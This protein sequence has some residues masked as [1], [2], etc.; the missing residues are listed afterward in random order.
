MLLK[1]CLFILAVL[2]FSIVF[3][4]EDGFSINTFHDESDR[5]FIDNTI[6]QFMQT[7]HIPGLSIAIAKQED[8]VLAKGYGF[9]DIENKVPV[10]ITHQ[11][12]IASVSKPITAV[13]I[14]Q[15]REQGE[16]T[17]DDKIFGTGGILASEYPV[18]DE[19]LKKITIQHLLEHTAGKEWA[20]DSNDPMFQ[21]PDL[22]QTALIRWVLKNRLITKTPGSEYAYSNFAYCLLGRV[23]EKLRGVA[24]QQYVRKNILQPIN[25]NSFAIGSK[26]LANTIFQVRYYP[27]SDEDPYWLPIARM[28][29]HGGWIS[30]AIDLVKFSMSIDGRRKDIL[31][32]KSIKLMTTASKHNSNYALGWNVNQYNNWW[33]M[34]SLPG[35]ASILVRTEH[36]YNWA[37]LLNSRSQDKDFFNDLDQLT[38]NLINGIKAL[39]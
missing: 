34:G 29:S 4:E 7:Y 28:D 16:L 30:N 15:L 6:Q 13:A 36:G 32:S 31:N 33:H 3:A 9:A 8:L 22:S 37:V 38:W 27:D 11:F 21:K 2:P 10:N 12:R 17:L 26:K 20:N 18:E 19:L 5:Q 35:T 24:Y 1:R 39:N 14:M 25:A 23:I